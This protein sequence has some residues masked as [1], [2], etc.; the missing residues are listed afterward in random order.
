MAAEM[1][2]KEEEANR[3]FYLQNLYNQQY[4]A[5]MNEITTFGMAQAAIERNLTLLEKKD[6]LK[7]SNILVS[8]EGGTYI[9]A[10]IKDIKKVMTYVGAGYLIEKDIEQAREFLKKSAEV[11]KSTIGRMIQDKQKLENELMRIQFAI[12]T[13]QQGGA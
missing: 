2:N 9:E 11:S 12:E 10:D 1:S 8:G 7:G 4:E 3:L 5:L 6:E 13:M